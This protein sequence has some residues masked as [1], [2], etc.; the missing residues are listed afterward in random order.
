MALHERDVFE[1]VDYLLSYQRNSSSGCHNPIID[2]ADQVGTSAA[3]SLQSLLHRLFPEYKLSVDRTTTE[4]LWQ[5]VVC[6]YKMRPD[7]LKRELC[8]V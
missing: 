7:K 8:R 2:N 6:F 4:K 1:T 5:S 3:E